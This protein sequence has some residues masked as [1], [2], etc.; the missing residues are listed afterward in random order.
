LTE[1]ARDG[2]KIGRNADE[3]ISICLNPVVLAGIDSCLHPCRI[4]LFIQFSN[5][6]VCDIFFRNGLRIRF[7]RIIGYTNSIQASFGYFPG[8]GDGIA[9]MYTAHGDKKVKGWEGKN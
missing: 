6:L 5:N 7:N 2:K 9:Y 1:Q 3:C 4:G 8:F